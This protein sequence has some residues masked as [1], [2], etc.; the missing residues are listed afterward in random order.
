[1]GVYYTL[2][3]KGDPNRAR[4]TIS[5]L[6]VEWK[7]PIFG[8]LK[9]YVC[10]PIGTSVIKTTFN[11]GAVIVN[12]ANP[13][14]AGG[15][16]TNVLGIGTA[17]WEPVEEGPASP[18]DIEKWLALARQSLGDT[19][20]DIEVGMMTKE[21]VEKYLIDHGYVSITQTASQTS[22]QTITSSS[23]GKKQIIISSTENE[24][25]KDIGAY[26][27]YIIIGVGIVALA[28]VLKR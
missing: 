18:A 14:E 9:K 7:G 24:D 22:G 26:L 16:F 4:N 5:N 12:L 23:D 28:F 15:F 17:G 10:A 6:A 1:M 3:V 27:P 19:L 20:V 2:I 13:K 21:E 25:Q 8:V 11:Y